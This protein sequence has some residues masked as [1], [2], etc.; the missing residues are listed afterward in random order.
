MG[1][2]GGGG[3]ENGESRFGALRRE[4]NEELGIEISSA[5]PLLR[6]IHRSPTKTTDLDVWEVSEWHGFA[7][8]REGQKIEWIT[9]SKLDRY[10]FPAANR[11]VITAVGLPRTVFTVPDLARFPALSLAALDHWLT[12]GARCFLLYNQ[13]FIKNP[14]DR[15]LTQVGH[16]LN[17]F[18][19]K[20]IFDWSLETATT[21]ADFDYGRLLESL[22]GQIDCDILA[23]FP[24]RTPAQLDRAEQ[25]GAE[26]L[27]IG[28]VRSADFEM[29]NDAIG[30]SET[31]RLVAKTMIP[32]FA[33]GPLE[34]QDIA[35]AIVSGCQGLVLPS[36]DWTTDPTVVMN[37]VASTISQVEVGDNC[38]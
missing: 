11:T 4:L 24:C 30:W 36:S 15:V 7:R 28:P 38:F 33:F 6:L 17:R 16:R 21:A 8:G 25:V 34:P 9:P 2:S 10:A 22:R 18:N 1:V 3:R 29:E 5:L 31:L 32:A 19:A 14:D 37:A 12:A 35:R 27:L 23:G 20:L 13:Y 26:L